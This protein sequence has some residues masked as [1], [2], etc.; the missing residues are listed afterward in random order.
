MGFFAEFSAWLNRILEDYV[1]STTATIAGVLEPVI[2]TLATLY[3]VVWGYLHL[4]GQIE[5]PFVTGVKRIFLL[6]IILGISLSLWYYNEII[7]DTFFFAPSV[8][9]A[10]VIGHH[11]SVVVV[12]GVLAAGNDVAAALSQRASLLEFDLSVYFAAFGVQII[13]GVTAVYTMFLLV[14]SRIAL[15]VLLALGPF[16][17]A[18]L[19]FDTTKR[20]F[21]SWIAQLANYA[22]ITILVGLVAALML[23]VVTRTADHVLAT[24]GNVQV[25]DAIR[26]CVAAGLTLLVMRQV[27]PIAAGLA[28]GLALSS[29]GVVSAAVSW[30]LDTASS[31][32][33]DFGRGLMDRETGRL[34]SLTRKAGYYSRQGLSRTA[35]ALWSAARRP[36]SVGSA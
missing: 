15:S 24:G 10:H 17:I 31:G 33:R 25:A 20:F 22:F 13:V 27:M 4:M 6:A 3:I 30:G 8:L 16:F 11:D 5:E 32:A 34:D 1:S 19:M 35:R 2:V 21:E 28:S 23:T 26:L 18:L 9:A 14:L 12:D 36:N 29:F 7:V